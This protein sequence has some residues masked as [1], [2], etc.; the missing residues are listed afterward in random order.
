MNLFQSLEH[1]SPGQY[2]IFHM[3]ATSLFGDEQASNV[4]ELSCL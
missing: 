3:E 1:V 2:F 4:T